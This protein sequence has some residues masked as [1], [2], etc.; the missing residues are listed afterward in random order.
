MIELFCPVCVVDKFRRVARL[1][2]GACWLHGRQSPATAMP[3]TFGPDHNTYVTKEQAMSHGDSEAAYDDFEREHR[4]RRMPNVKIVAVGNHIG[5]FVEKLRSG[6]KV[7][8][9]RPDVKGNGI[10][11]KVERLAGC[12]SMKERAEVTIMPTGER[13]ARAITP[14]CLRTS[15]A[16]IDRDI[17]E[18]IKKQA[19][20]NLANL[21]AKENTVAPKNEKIP[22]FYVGSKAV[23]SPRNGEREP[24]AKHT[25]AEA[26]AHATRLVEASGGEQ[27]IVKIIKVVKR[28]PMPI[29]VE[30]V[31]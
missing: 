4:L 31:S 2:N 28:R 11:M 6:E 19:I 10:I 14:N 13:P 3:G 23:F 8:L 21:I 27:Y 12:E 5:W 20:A 22:R 15:Y 16:D 30:K 24:W 18:N 7:W 9:S 29:V 1:H 17:V 26:I 25:E